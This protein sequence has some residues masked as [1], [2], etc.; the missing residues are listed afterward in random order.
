MCVE[1]HEVFREL[2]IPI[3]NLTFTK[4]QL[5]SAELVSLA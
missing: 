2:N 4:G 1:K 5:D 3:T